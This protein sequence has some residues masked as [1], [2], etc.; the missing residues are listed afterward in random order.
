LI[1]KTVELQF[2]LPNDSEWSEAEKAERREIAQNLYSDLLANPDKFEAIAGGRES[3][4][5]KY[6]EYNKVTLSQLPTIYKENIGVLD[7]TADW[8]VSP[9]M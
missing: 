5:I 2:K 4:N 9:L 8:K 1:V 3:E 6:T 7:E